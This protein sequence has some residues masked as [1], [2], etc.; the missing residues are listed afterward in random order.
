MN[1]NTG[2][3]MSFRAH[4]LLLDV[5]RCLAV[6]LL[7]VAGQLGL[8]DLVMLAATTG[9]KSGESLMLAGVLDIA[10]VLTFRCCLLLYVVVPSV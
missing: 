3:E 5:V 1:S 7:V 10:A 6:A 4:T 8:L 2:M 9:M